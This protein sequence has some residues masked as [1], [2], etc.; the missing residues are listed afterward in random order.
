MPTKWNEW[1]RG[2]DEL[3]EEPLQI[4]VPPPQI[5]EEC[6]DVGQLLNWHR[7]CV[8]PAT[9]EDMIALDLIYKKLYLL[10]GK[11]KRVK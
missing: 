7:Y 11:L 8:G 3:G 5:V 4:E 9:L 2:R 6:K 1:K 10:Q